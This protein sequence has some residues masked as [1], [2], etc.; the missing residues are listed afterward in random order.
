MQVTSVRPIKTGDRR[1]FYEAPHNIF[2]VPPMSNSDTRGTNRGYSSV[3]L[4]HILPHRNYSIVEFFLALCLFLAV[5]VWV[6]G[7]CLF[8]HM[9]II[10]SH[11]PVPACSYPPGITPGIDRSRINTRDGY[12]ST[13]PKR[14]PKIFPLSSHKCRVFGACLFE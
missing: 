4:F 2:V 11:G 10:I 12:I 8:S 6:F 5:F 13:E 1:R 7:V 14:L 3:V 9:N